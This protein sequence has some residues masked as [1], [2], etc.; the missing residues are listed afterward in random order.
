MRSRLW[1][2]FLL[3]PVTSVRHHLNHL[4]TSQVKSSQVYCTTIYIHCMANTYN[5]TV[6]R[7]YRH[8]HINIYNFKCPLQLIHIPGY[9][10]YQV[11]YVRYRYVTQDKWLP[12]LESRRVWSDGMKRQ[13]STNKVP[14][15]GRS[16]ST[17]SRQDR[18]L[19][20]LAVR[21]R[22]HQQ[23]SFVVNSNMPMVPECLIKQFVFACT[24]LELHSR[25]P[26][27]VPP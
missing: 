22:F 12:P 10:S 3:V 5:I 27:V 2:M 17:M 11:R 14:G 8:L 7:Q 16:R 23:L 9:G 1:L 20:T 13:D 15:Q 4:N 21:S 6:Q 18:Y 24:M 19:M 26:L 25:R